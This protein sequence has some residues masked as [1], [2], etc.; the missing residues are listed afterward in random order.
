MLLGKIIAALCVVGS[1]TAL[2]LLSPRDT[3]VPERAFK[4]VIDRMRPLDDAM[5]RIRNGVG[6][7]VEQTMNLLRLD[8]DL[9]RQIRDSSKRIRAIPELTQVEASYLLTSMYQVSTMASSIAT[10]WITWKNMVVA[11]NKGPDVL[12]Q[13]SED[14]DA[15]L[16]LA[17]AINGKAPKAA[18]IQSVGSMWKSTLTAPIDKAVKEYR[19]R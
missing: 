18:A 2:P 16:E 5:R 15:L 4:S 1:V 14:S 9:L 6:D 13:L 8:D 11:A 17:D 12:R 7:P 10:S 3:T 19:W